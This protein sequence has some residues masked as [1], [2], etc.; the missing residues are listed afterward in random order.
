[1]G[2]GGEAGWDAPDRGERRGGFFKAFGERDGATARQCTV[3]YAENLT[4]GH[5]LP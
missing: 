4:R 1:M 2:H 3:M 5:I